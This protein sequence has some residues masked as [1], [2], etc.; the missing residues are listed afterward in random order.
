MK[1]NIYPKNYKS[2]L[3][4]VDTQIA[5]KLI[6]DT[7]ERE[8][9]K[10]L[11][12]M[13]VSAPLF[14]EPETGLNDNLSGFEKAVNF[15]VN[16]DEK[17]LEIVQSLAKWKRYA[18]NKYNIDGLYTDMNAIR[19]FEDLDNLHSLYVDQW[20]WE[21]RLVPE[22]RK[23]GTL[24]GVVKRIYKA[25]LKTYKLLIKKYPQLENNNLPRDVVFITTKE[26]EARYPNLSRKERENAICKE[27]GVVFLIGIGGKLKDGQPH[28]ARAADYD[29]WK[30]NGDILLWYEPLQIAFE[31]S[32]MGIRVNK[33]SLVKQ[34]KAKKEEYKLSLPY[35]QQ[36]L[37]DELPLSIG[38]GIGQSRLCMYLL[39]KIHI[40]E[41]Q[42]S[43]WP[44][45]DI[46]EFKKH[47]VNLL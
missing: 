19:R 47:N 10:E 36:I 27:Y 18:L 4:L 9:A 20:D 12:L 16:E 33:N 40:G 45:E 25:F 44:E 32:S 6:K 7:F 38:G 17:N 15:V 35:H 28:D 43:Y 5:I 29:D 13:R 39:K 22:E 46:K 2:V 8:L 26:L 1:N 37:N 3:N 31:L 11:D 34:L 23:M 24:K 14:V 30:M 21:R 41:V 42:S